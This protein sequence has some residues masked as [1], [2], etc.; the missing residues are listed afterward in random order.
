MTAL[1]SQRTSQRN[2]LAAHFLLSAVLL[3]GL[4]GRSIAAEQGAAKEVNNIPNSEKSQST[5][6]KVWNSPVPPASWTVTFKYGS[7]V[8]PDAASHRP[9]SVSVTA[10]GDNSVEVIEYPNRK[11]EVWKTGPLTLVSAPDSNEATFR[12]SSFTSVGTDPEATVTNVKRSREGTVTGLV[13]GALTTL[14]TEDPD[15]IELTEF[16]WIRPEMFK[17]KVEIAGE[18]VLI[19][20]EMQAE[21]SLGVAKP[22]ASPSPSYPRGPLGGIPL[23]PGIRAAAILEGSRLPRYLQNGPDISIYS[24]STPAQTALAI[25]PK[26][27]NHIPKPASKAKGVT[28]GLFV[29]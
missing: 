9:A 24:F 5:E 29:P 1:S 19:Y 17:G 28:I 23:K 15:W 20:A 25:P 13:N 14:G 11:T 22:G 21:A 27:A 16:D 18:N 8:S 4:Y 6:S 10:I 3:G 26:V 2:A 12:P 7:T